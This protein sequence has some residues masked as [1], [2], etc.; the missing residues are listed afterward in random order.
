MNVRIVGRKPGMGI[1]RASLFG[2][3]VAVLAWGW[4]AGGMAAEKAGKDAAAEVKAMT[5]A[6]TRIVWL[7]DGDENAAPWGGGLKTKVMG[8]DTDDGKGVRPIFPDD[9][10]Y[11]WV[12]FTPDGK[13]VASTHAAKGESWIEYINWDGTGLRKLVSGAWLAGISGDPDGRTVWLYG[14]KDENGKLMIRRYRLDD[15]SISEIMWDKNKTIGRFTISTDGKMGAGVYDN[16]GTGKCCVFELPNVAWHVVNNGCQPA[17]LPGSDPYRVFVFNGDHRSGSIFTNPT[18]AAKMTKQPLSLGRAFGVAGRYE[19]SFP[20]WSNNVHYMLLSSPFT[21]PKN[22]EGIPFPGSEKMEGKYKRY[23]DRVEI[24]I[25]RLDEGMTKIEKWVQI[26][27][28]N[29]GDYLPEAWIEP[30]AQKA[31]TTA[32]VRP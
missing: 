31:P 32:P 25:G 11:S 23:H 21:T 5:G 16:P 14:Q 18:D 6:H 22:E 19:V 7:Q 9:G 29:V 13:G 3:A 4:P 8:L 26:T 24:S 12:Y 28:N 1:V 17:M 27:D 30:G 10:G 15:P 20:K 2:L